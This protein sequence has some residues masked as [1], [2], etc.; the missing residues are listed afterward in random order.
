MQGVLV[1]ASAAARDAAITS[2]QEG[3]CCYLKDTDAVLTYSG[4]AWVGFD[5]SNAI[6]NSIVDAKGD[7]VAASGADT[8]ARLAVG[9]NGETLVADSSTATGLSYQENYAAGKNKIMNGDFSVNQ[10]N[11][12]TTTTTAE[13]NFDR[14]RTVYS[15]GTSTTTAET[16]TPGA[17][18]VAGYEGK[19]FYRVAITGQASAT[20]FVRY[21]Q[22]VESVRTFAG[23]TTTYSFW[24][25]ASS[26]TPKIAF[27][28]SQY[29]GTGGSP[30]A[31]VTTNAGTVTLSTSWARYS[32]TV[33]IPSLS[34][35][36]IGTDNNSTLSMRLFLSAGAS[37][38][39]GQSIGYQNVTIDTWGHQWESGSVATAFQTATGTIQGELAA[40]QR[41]YFRMNANNTYSPFG[42]GN[43]GS[44]TL[45][46]IMV[47]HP[48]P[49]RTVTSSVDF[50]NLAVTRFG[51]PVFAV[52]A[53]ALQDKTT[54]ITLIS[55]TND[56]SSYTAGSYCALSANNSTSAFIGFSAEL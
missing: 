11:F 12:T 53:I 17:A 26:G 29:F 23:D 19:N 28:V 30:S 2:P 44:A 33:A 38:T 56:N 21:A 8:P 46:Y 31:T 24:A 5:D 45:S 40:C 6:Q 54:N 22:A 15:G 14:W 32:V 50:S 20:D 13:F 4:A 37:V 41:Y 36:T 42:S 1:F 52:T 9:N 7:L 47:N 18:P 49:M 39:E 3:Q 10:R 43:A 48:V 27:N 34:G 35:K 51:S 55:T 25:K 16:F